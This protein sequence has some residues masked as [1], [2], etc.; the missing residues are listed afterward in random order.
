[1]CVHLHEIPHE[2]MNE[3]KNKN[4]SMNLARLDVVVY[5]FI[6][7]L[8]FM[9]TWKTRKIRSYF[10]NLIAIEYVIIQRKHKILL[11]SYN[12]VWNVEYGSK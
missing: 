8:V 6:I 2:F 12:Y 9:G 10:E 11:N 3:F 1:M 5:F 7:S 4:E